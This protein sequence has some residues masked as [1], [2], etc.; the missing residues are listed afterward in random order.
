MLCV[1]AFAATIRNKD[2][3]QMVRQGASVTEIVNRINASESGFALYEE[4][5][6]A[7]RKDGVP[8]VV[9]RAM[10]ARQSGERLQLETPAGVTLPSTT[11]SSGA[12]TAPPPPKA[13]APQQAAPVHPFQ[14]VPESRPALTITS[15]PDDAEVEVNE[16]WV[17]KTPV[18]FFTGPAGGTLRLSVSKE[19]F[20]RWS[21][22]LLSE[23]GQNKLSAQLKPR[24]GIPGEAQ[25]STQQPTPPA[26]SGQVATDSRRLSNADVVRM[27]Q[28][29]VASDLI[30][31]AISRAESVQF[32]L[33]KSDVD[34]L[35]ER[36]VPNDII[37][38]MGA[39]VAAP[40]VPTASSSAKRSEAP[41]AGPPSVPTQVQPPM[42]RSPEQPAAQITNASRASSSRTIKIR[43]YITSVKSPMEFEIED[44][45]ITRDS[46]IAL[47][48]ERSEEVGAESQATFR[49]EDIRVGTE[50]EIKGE[51]NEQ[52]GDLKARSVKVNLDEHK[53]LKRTALLESTPN[54]TRTGS[55]WEGSL[56][57]DGQRL[58][59]RQDTLVTIKPNA[60]QRKA[61]NASKRAL[62]KAPPAV[63]PTTSATNEEGGQPLL[64]SAQIKL[65]MFVSYEG[66]RQ[67]DGAILTSKLEFTDNEL[68]PTEARMWK[69]LTPKIKQS[70]FVSTKPGELRIP[71]IGKF[72]LVP[73]S[74]VQQY[75]QG[76]G[77]SLIPA[78]QRNL[79]TGDPNKIPFQF[80][81]VRQGTPNAFALA[82]GTVVVHS[83]LITA[84]EDEAQLAFVLS[85]EIAHATQEHTYRQQ[86]YHKK[87]LIALRVGAIVAVAATGNRNIGDLAKLTEAAIR[88]GYSRSL[89]NQADRLGTE[90]VTAAGYDPREAPRVWKVMAKKSGDQRTNF[91]WSTHDNFVTR[92]SYLMAELRNNYPDVDFQSS[93]RSSERFSKVA[94]ILLNE[95]QGKRKVKVRLSSRAS[96]T[97]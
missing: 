36:G 52:T 54:L 33:L 91:F 30:I 57:V 95:Q 84:L 44:Y 56:R 31:E 40:A 89:E 50:L 37:R 46:T 11:P 7:L 27:V 15:T 90:Y 86:Q 75:I 73:N 59:V 93:I 13:E 51:Y 47:E 72:T 6:R 69:R 92:R 60:S 23:P 19:G 79:P 58:I 97:P 82:N 3:V 88:N 63:T 55:A 14:G 17:G 53:T 42:P 1:T 67:P 74:E 96:T 43:G 34:A 2:V 18:T 83:S 21:T 10:F 22:Q 20:E 80:F 66:I 8:E 62:K 68:T 35:A 65:N 87:A 41:S 77:M 28:S 16:T 5:V 81:V 49:P 61:E 45:R 85:H 29:K 24:N 38:A 26:P 39:K 9:I 12:V 78:Y 25:G 71:E 4:D 48:F 70:D 32:S 94:G 64:Q 76:L